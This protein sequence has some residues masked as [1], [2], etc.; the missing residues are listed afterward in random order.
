MNRN[1]KFQKPQGLTKPQPFD[2]HDKKRKRDSDKDG[3][4]QQFESMAQKMI[5]FARKTPDRFRMRPKNNG[6]KLNA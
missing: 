5:S 2:L 1:C 4:G 3:K 6:E